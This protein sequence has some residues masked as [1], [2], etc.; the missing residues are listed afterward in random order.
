MIQKADKNRII[1]PNHMRL[2]FTSLLASDETTNNLKLLKERATS[3]NELLQL[4][5]N[6]KL[7]IRE[8]QSIG[9]LLKGR[10]ALETSQALNISPKTVEYYIDSAKTKLNCLTRADIFD[11]ILEYK[12]I[13]I[14][15]SI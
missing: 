11:R 9:Y 5:L 6:T 4:H 13:N 10:T 12:L 7:S 14:I 8:L 15:T 3:I 2:N 1:I